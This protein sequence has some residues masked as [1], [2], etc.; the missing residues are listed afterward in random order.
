MDFYTTQQKHYCGVDLHARTMYICV[1]SEQGDVLLPRS[2]PFDA[3]APGSDSR[4]QI[5]LDPEILSW[6]FR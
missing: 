6:G 3:A 5:Q 4:G 1:L 2:L